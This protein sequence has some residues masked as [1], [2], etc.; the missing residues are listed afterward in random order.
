MGVAVARGKD[1]DEARA[2]AKQAASSIKPV[3]P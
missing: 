3:K 1:T 2:R